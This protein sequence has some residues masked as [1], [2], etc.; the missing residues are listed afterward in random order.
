[1]NCTSSNDEDVVK[2]ALSYLFEIL[3]LGKKS[4]NKVDKSYL[5]MVDNLELFNVY[6]CG[7]IV[8]DMI[9]KPLS[10]VEY[11]PKKYTKVF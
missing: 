10:T 8:F 2:L 11:L 9:I 6:P 7:K 5:A 3:L 1:M 4:K